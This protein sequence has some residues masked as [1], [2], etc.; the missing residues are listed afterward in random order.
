MAFVRAV[1]RCCSIA[2][3]L[4]CIG[5]A[6]GDTFQVILQG[7]V[8]MQDG[9]PPPKSVGLQRICSD[10][11]GSAPGPITSK[12]GE[13]LW[14][15]EVDPMRT[16]VCRLEATLEG[17]VSS[18]IDISNINGYTSK[19]LTLAPLVLRPRGGDPDTIDVSDR[20]VPSR[21]KSAWKAAMKA[22]DAGNMPETGKQLQEVVKAS[23]KFA[24]GWN[25]LGIISGRL[26]MPAEARDAFEHAISADPKLLPAYLGLA[27]ICIKTKDWQCVS[28]SAGALVKLD[29][30]HTFPEIYLHQAVALYELKDLEG[31]EAS[32][33][34][35]IRLDAG[36]R[37]PRAEYVLGRILEAKGDAA[38]AREHISKYLALDPNS[39]DMDLV[40]AHLENIGKPE[41]AGIEPE[42]ELP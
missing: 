35:A 42:L 16:R 25:T 19:T 33:Q 2:G 28:K 17:Y 26:E 3:L 1:A 24:Q 23:P 10:E 14:R 13:Y 30:K 8:I 4:Y 20:E 41:A 36:H 37:M 6:F 18:S 38:G 7:K 15:M 39:V 40:R 31:G 32:A 22:L 5:P 27:R 34:E 11:S 21:S 12:K 29:N 9:S